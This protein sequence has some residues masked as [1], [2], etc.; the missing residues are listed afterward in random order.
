MIKYNNFEEFKNCFNLNPEKFQNI[1]QHKTDRL[2]FSAFI[3]PT[4]KTK[5]TL[6]IENGHE[7]RTLF[8]VYFSKYKQDK[9]GIQPR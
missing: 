1:T 8:A 9:D 2:G 7:Y 6:G 4:E 5:K 3:L